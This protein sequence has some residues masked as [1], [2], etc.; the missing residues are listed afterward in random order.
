MRD[1]LNN[2]G[3]PRPPSPPNIRALLKM[4]V[5]DPQ[6]GPSKPPAVLS[7][8]GIDLKELGLGPALEAELEKDVKR[9]AF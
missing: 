7:A 2:K 4:E 3:G 1:P 8:L 6:Y 5:R 9:H